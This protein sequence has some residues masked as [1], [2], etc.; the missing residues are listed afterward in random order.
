MPFV[1]VLVEITV[2][3][4]LSTINLLGEPLLTTPP[5]SILA[6]GMPV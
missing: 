5:E 3:P 2:V 6:L 4:E 1:K